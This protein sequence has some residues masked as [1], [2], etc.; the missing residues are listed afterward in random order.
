[1]S[2]VSTNETQLLQ[3]IM[4]KLIGEINILLDLDL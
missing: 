1:M 4:R 2:S 3:W